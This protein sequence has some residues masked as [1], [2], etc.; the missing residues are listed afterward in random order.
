MTCTPTSSPTR[1]AAAAPASVAAFTDATSPRTIAVTRPASTFCQ[2]TNTTL[3]VLTMASVA[4]TIPTKPRVSTSPS[5]SPGLSLGLRISA[6]IGSETDAITT[7]TPRSQDARAVEPTSRK[8]A[9]EICRHDGVP[10]EDRRG[11]RDPQMAYD[12]L[13]EDV[14]EV[15]RDREVPVLIP[16]FHRKAGPL[17]VDLAALEPAAHRKHRVAMSMVGPAVSVFRDRPPKLRHRQNDHVGHPVAKVGE[18]GR[19]PAAKIIEPRGQLASCGPFVHMV[20]PA[21]QFRERDF[22][23]EI[24]LDELADLH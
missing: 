21:A 15:C 11:I 3:A 16:V 14:P 17:A 2:P 9:G 8:Q 6:G 20:V 10:R 22:E 4:S 19:Q 18:E 1:R 23:A 13:C 7:G 12:H 5:A 24:C